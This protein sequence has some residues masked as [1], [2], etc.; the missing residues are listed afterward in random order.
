MAPSDSRRFEQGEGAPTLLSEERLIELAGKAQ[1]PAEHDAL[2]EHYLALAKRYEAQVE[3]HLA[4]ARMYRANPNR[5]G[6]DPVTHCD[7]LVRI[8]RDSAQEARAIATEHEQ[9]A[10]A[11]RYAAFTSLPGPA[12]PVSPTRQDREAPPAARGTRSRRFR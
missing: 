5:R 7:R 6:G 10:G 1:T 4:M 8:A 9:M 12:G 3:D 11:S 2:R